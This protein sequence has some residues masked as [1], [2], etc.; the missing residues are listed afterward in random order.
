MWRLSSGIKAARARSWQLTFTA[1][2]LQRLR[3]RWTFEA[4]PLTVHRR[5]DQFAFCV[6]TRQQLKVP[7]FLDISTGLYS[8]TQKF[9]SPEDVVSM[10][11]RNVSIYLQFN[12]ALQNKRRISTSSWRWE[13][14]TS[15][16][17]L[18]MHLSSPLSGWNIMNPFKV[19]VLFISI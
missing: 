13:T 9:F 11:L 8:V 4:M 15:F 14:Q 17:L 10:F 5:R 2:P 18:I 7:F 1:C 6:L 16:K 12:T 19:A 3:N